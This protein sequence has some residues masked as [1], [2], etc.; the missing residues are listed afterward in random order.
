MLAE[1]TTRFD[2]RLA[3]CLDFLKKAGMRQMPQG[4]VSLD[5]PAL[6]VSRPQAL[7]LPIEEIAH[8]LGGAEQP[9]AGVYLRSQGD[10][11]GQTF[12]VLEHGRA[13]RLVDLILGQTPGV[14]QRL[15]AEQRSILAEFGQ[16]AAAFFFN[17]LAGFSG[18]NL[19]PTSQ[20]VVVDMVGAILN[21]AVAAHGDVS[22]YGL[23]LQFTLVNQATGHE[24]QADFWMIPDPAMVDALPT[25]TPSPA[26]RAC[27]GLPPLN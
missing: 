26:A 17:T 27:L 11:C 4:L 2:T 22:P 24:V 1:A 21:T 18:L 13:L 12:L 15:G 8:L 19:Q 16:L 10:L 20:A 14:T 6:Q 7:V 3:E 23:M 25:K 5:R 9:A